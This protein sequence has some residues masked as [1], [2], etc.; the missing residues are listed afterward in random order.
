M[1]LK[2]RERQKGTAM[3]EF[4]LCFA[5]FWLPLFL[6]TIAL[7]F[8]LNEAI[9]V[10]QVCRDVTHMYSQGIDF[11][12]STYQNLLI[13][14]APALGL[15]SSG[16]NGEM[17]L[18][19]V[20]LADSS[21]CN[22]YLPPSGAGC[23]NLNHYVVTRRVVIG[24]TGTG[25]PASNFGIPQASIVDSTNGHILSSAQGVP[26]YLTDVTARADGFQGT[27]G[28]TLP[29]QQYAYV[30]EM[31]VKAVFWSSAGVNGA[32]ARNIF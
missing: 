31:Y 21:L 2:S 10:T 5:L 8:N 27:T 26:Y 15:A 28:I 17:I 3:V 4:G 25:F 13:N 1:A 32:S 12:S 14:L 24:N 19:T 7:G 29:S 9:L 11:S 20:T 18:T 22:S 6:G 30:G 16:G 23:N